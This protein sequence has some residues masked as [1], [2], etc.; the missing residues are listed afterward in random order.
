MAQQ[1][2][3]Y[4]DAKTPVYK[5]REDI[6]K[7]LRKVGATGLAWMDGDHPHEP[8]KQLV[9]LRFIRPEAGIPIAV[10]ILLAVPRSTARTEA[11]REKEQ[12]QLDRQYHRALYWYVK[13]QVEAV[14]FGLVQFTEAFMPHLEMG[15]GRTL[16][17]TAMPQYLQG[18]AQGIIPVLALLPGGGDSR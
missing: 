15:D 18:A 17:Q 11:A 8:G 12:G 4:E 9:A 13:A 5:S 1:R 6:T 3:P 14:E 7:L 10:R 2:I 16:Y